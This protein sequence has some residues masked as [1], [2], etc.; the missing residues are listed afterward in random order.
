MSSDS[1]PSKRK[2]FNVTM[3]FKKPS[4]K[5]TFRSDLSHRRQAETIRK[6]RADMSVKA[7][8]DEWLKTWT[9]HE[10]HFKFLL[11]VLGEAKRVA[12]SIGHP[13]TAREHL[14]V[15]MANHVIDEMQDPR[16]DHYIELLHEIATLRLFNLTKAAIKEV[17]RR[18]AAI[19]KPLATLLIGAVIVIPEPSNINVVAN[20]LHRFTDASAE[21][22]LTMSLV[23]HMTSI[24]RS[25][26]PGPNRPRSIMP[27]AHNEEAKGSEG[28]PTASSG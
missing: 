9:S 4:L 5:S 6:Y 22:A 25:T 7:N 18:N 16:E 1:P 11:A 14:I 20:V 26:Y 12:A 21:T 13:E 24:V 8:W 23:S 19:V 17:T 10:C 15:R 3:T 2:G 27:P 28:D